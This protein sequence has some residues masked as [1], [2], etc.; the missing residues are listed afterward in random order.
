MRLVRVV[1]LCVGARRRPAVRCLL[2]VACACLCAPARR[3][4][5]LLSLSARLVSRV[6]VCLSVSVYSSLHVRGFRCSFPVHVGL[7][8]G[9]MV[10]PVGGAGPA[11]RSSALS[12]SPLPALP[13]LS[14]PTMPC[15]RSV[16]CMPLSV[17]RLVGVGEGEGSGR[18]PHPRRRLVSC[19][20]PSPFTTPSFVDCAL[21]RI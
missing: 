14:L 21:E 12:L 6:H 7:S 9:V 8:K 3:A 4:A 17:C 16:P 1:C 19:R 18:P 2:P 11:V 10:G 5:V 13:R 20:P 15:T